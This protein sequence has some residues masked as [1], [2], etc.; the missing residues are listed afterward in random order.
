MAEKC[1]Q[2]LQGE[3]HLAA[4]HQG[5]LRQAVNHQAVNRQGGN[6]QEDKHLEG[7]HLEGNHQGA[8][9]QGASHQGASHHPAGGVWTDG[10]TD[11]AAKDWVLAKGFKDP[12]ALALSAHNLEKLTGGPPE[13]LFRIPD[14]AD[15]AAW[16]EIYGKMG[17]P[18]SAEKYEIK[19]PEGDNGEFAKTARQ[20]F[21]DMGL[22]QAQVTG[23]TDKW[24]AHLAETMKNRSTQTAEQQ[25]ADL[26]L[27]KNEWGP[28]YNSKV[29]I[30]DR[31][32]QAF[33]MS[34]EQLT[35]LKAVMGVKDG[36]SFMYNIGSKVTLPGTDFVPPGGKPGFGGMTIEQAKAEIAT[37]RKSPEFQQEFVSKD[38]KVK[39]EAQEKMARLHQ[40]A[41]PDT[42][43][44]NR[45]SSN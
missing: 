33:G 6:H 45:A 24:N 35:Q 36:M 19:L 15:P 23:I 3:H 37:L 14:T 41:Y 18:E 16:Q 22:S 40:I 29:E 12:T 8:S 17:R 44:Y 9:H 43:S 7:N 31:A 2:C 20:W 5:E 32:A 28:E 27:V 10:I 1:S 13:K 38:P 42:T 26:Q 34:D 21:F 4:H 25:A 30:I 11:Q 39:R